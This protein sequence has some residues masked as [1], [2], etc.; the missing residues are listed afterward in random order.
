M[1][2]LTFRRLYPEIAQHVDEHLAI[3]V[4]G[5]AFAIIRNPLPPLMIR[6]VRSSSGIGLRLPSA[7]LT[8]STFLVWAALTHIARVTTCLDPQRPSPQPAAD[9]RSGD[10]RDWR[11]SL[12]SPCAASMQLLRAFVASAAASRCR[13]DSAAPRWS[14]PAQPLRFCRVSS[15]AAVAR[16][17]SSVASR[18]LSASCSAS[19][20]PLSLFLLLPGLLLLLFSHSLLLLGSIAFSSSLGQ[21]LLRFLPLLPLNLFAF[22][23]SLQLLLVLQRPPCIAASV[24]RTPS[25]AA[26]FPQV[27]HED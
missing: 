19:V 8:Y 20:L 1:P 4:K 10:P 7:G 26:L 21:R 27:R 24:C 22:L 25:G 23:A 15:V 2:V 3:R 5:P 6:S 11:A 13:W 14:S 16:F 9:R 17:C 18:C 12:A